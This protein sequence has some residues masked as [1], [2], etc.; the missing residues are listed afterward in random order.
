M[1][2]PLL[3]WPVHEG[4]QGSSPEGDREKGWGAR[5]AV[6][7]WDRLKALEDI[8]FICTATLVVFILW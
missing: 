6:G 1:S 4:E 8:S 3:G 2:I 7:V 5:A